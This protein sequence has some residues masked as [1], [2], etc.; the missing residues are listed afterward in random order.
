MPTKTSRDRF[1]IGSVCR[2]PVSLVDLYPTLIDLCDLKPKQDQDGVSLVP[3]LHNP[4][5]DSYEAVIT[6]F[7]RGNYSI[8][9]RRWRL[10]RYS[11]GSEELY[12]HATDP[13]EW[14]NVI[15]EKEHQEVRAGLRAWVPAR[16]RTRR[17]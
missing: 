5:A 2:Q 12:D 6:T 4:D 3:R 9:T 13:Q 14:R 10:I 7:D 17:Y 1:R 15:G 11:D 16:G 8:R